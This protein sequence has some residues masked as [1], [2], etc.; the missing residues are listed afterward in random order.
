MLY[1]G[2]VHRAVLRID[3]RRHS[4]VQHVAAVEHASNLSQATRCLIDE[5]LA[6]R[7]LAQQQAK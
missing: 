6:G 3:G 1:S 4:A 5:A 2:K 7:S